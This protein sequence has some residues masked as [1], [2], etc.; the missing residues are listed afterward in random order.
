M[1]KRLFVFGVL[2]VI[3][4][5]CTKRVTVTDNLP[6]PVVEPMPLAIG[7]RYDRRL[8]EYVHSEGSGRSTYV[9][10][11]GRSHVRLFDRLFASLFERVQPLSTLDLSS[12][13]APQIDVILHPTI[14]EYAFVTPGD[15][16]LDYYE[17][18]IRYRMSLYAPDGE[19]IGSLPV[20]G[21]GRSPSQMFKA[22]RSVGQA[23]SAAMRDAAAFM[24]IEFRDT[25]EI[26]QL[27][28]SK[29]NGR[30]TCS[31]DPYF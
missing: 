13:D 6:A 18:S 28:E 23:T 25:P 10:E 27:I 1:D 17:V 30:N 3:S 21:Y 20:T 16:G 7:V 5:A 14:E 8:R 12:Q 2:A 26:R 11:L 4:T 31:E 9:V 29:A 15:N 24:A 22:G 19:P